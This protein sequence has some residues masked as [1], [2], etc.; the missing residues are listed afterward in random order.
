MQSAVC[1]FVEAD[2]AVRTS[3]SRE[4]ANDTVLISALELPNDASLRCGRE[5]STSL[6]GNHPS[7]ASLLP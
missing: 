6:A 5:R 7:F 1:T 4:P 3:P 2:D